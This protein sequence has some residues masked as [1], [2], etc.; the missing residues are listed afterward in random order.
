MPG[1]AIVGF[2]LRGLCGQQAV[3]KCIGLPLQRGAIGGFGQCGNALVDGLRSLAAKLH[4]ALLVLVQ[5][6]RIACEPG[7]LR[8]ACRAQHG[9]LDAGGEPGVHAG[10]AAAP[11]GIVV[12][13]ILPLHVPVCIA[14]EALSAFANGGGRV[15]GLVQ[16]LAGLDVYR[17]RL[18]GVFFRDLCNGNAAG[19][20]KRN[21]A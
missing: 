21:N 19:Q 13:P 3:A 9:H 5:S 6:P 10:N 8:V 14:V 15:E 7:V 4:V 12:P 18:L 2:F 16:C 1:V 11:G 20:G 17:V